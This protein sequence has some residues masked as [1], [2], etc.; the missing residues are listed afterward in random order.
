[1]SVESKYSLL[2]FCVKGLDFFKL[3][4]SLGARV[5]APSEESN[6][7]YTL[8]TIK[9]KIA[10]RSKATD[11]K[12]VDIHLRRFESYSSQFVVLFFAKK[13]IF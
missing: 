8:F 7:T 6:F 3:F 9:E 12:S 13:S 4:K 2:V 10:E 11:C 1:M 5:R